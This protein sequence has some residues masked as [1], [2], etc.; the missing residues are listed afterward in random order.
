[1]KVTL[2]TSCLVQPSQPTWTGSMPLTESDQTGVITHVPTIYFYRPSEKW[3]TPIEAIFTTLKTSLSEVLGHFY[4]LAGR[5]RWIDGARLELE[6]NNQGVHLIQASCEAK[7]EDLGDFTPSPDFRH[8][9]PQVNYLAPI[10]EI[11][12]LLVQLTKFQ[13]GG[14]TLSYTISHAVA[15]GQSALHFFSEWARL[16]RGEPL[17]ALP[18]LDRKALR[19]GEPPSEQPRFHHAQFDPP[20]LLIG[21]SSS[22]DESKKKTTIAMLKMSTAQVEI[23]KNEA[24]ATGQD[25]TSRAYT[26]YEAI[27]GHIWRCVSK[28]RAHAHN[29]P[30]ALGICVDIRKRMDPPL[31]EKFFGNAIVD[32]IATSQSG[33]LITK[34]LSYAAGRIREAIDSVTSEYVHSAIDFLKNLEDF[35]RL[36]DIHA[37]RSNQGPFYGNPNLGVISWMALPL[38]GLD[39]GW[40]KEIYMA[41]GTHDCDGDSLILPG[42]DG[43]GSLVVALCLQAACME[44][45]KKFFYEDIHVKDFGLTA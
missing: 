15:D 8:L 21:Q 10:E 2:N 39:F 22:E 27:A 20:P 12:L 11:P 28:A 3:L 4:P 41:P 35:T 33:D 30:T 23:L 13:C 16:A 32:V 17:G 19:A 25:D 36:Q 45:F 5:L 26:R 29:Q 14:I 1:M 9:I 24:N 7:L 44:D 31:P 43:D 6:C 42:Y 40:G 37:L 38:Y 18:F 34:P